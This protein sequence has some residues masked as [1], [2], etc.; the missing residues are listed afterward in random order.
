MS[1]RPRSATTV[2]VS[3]PWASRNPAAVSSSSASRRATR[4]T[5]HPRVAH[6]SANAAPRPSD[7]PAISAHGPYCS[8][9][10]MAADATAR[11]CRGPPITTVRFILTMKRGGA[12]RASAAVAAVLPVTLA[13]SM[14][15]AV[16]ASKPRVVA[17]FYPLAYA[18]Q[19][20]GDGRVTVSNLTPAGAEPHDLELTPDQIDAVLDADLMLELGHN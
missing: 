1:A 9:N 17:S 2:R 14:Q 15:W 6:S 12:P 5:L 7:A 18:A 16:A 11:P 19:R 8:E 13:A 3:M 4:T 10:S 20:V